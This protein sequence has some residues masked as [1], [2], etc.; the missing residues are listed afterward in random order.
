MLGSTIY[1]DRQAAALSVTF[2]N[3]PNCDLNP[4]QQTETHKTRTTNN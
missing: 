1:I 3:R 2:A 4:Q